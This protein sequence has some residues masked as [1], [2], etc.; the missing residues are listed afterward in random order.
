MP[1]RKKPAKE[2]RMKSTVIASSLV[3]AAALLLAACGSDDASDSAAG[4][5]TKQVAVKLT[6]AGCEP[7]QMKLDAGRVEFKVTNGGTGRVSEF[8]V[9]SGSRILGEKENLTPGLSG[10]FSITLQPGDYTL[11]CP[12]GSSAA[13]GTLTVTGGAGSPVA[14]PVSDAAAAAASAYHAYVQQQVAQLV[15]ATTAFVNAVKAGDSA[16]AQALYA[17]ARVPYERI[18]PVAE[19]FGDLD[20]QIDAREG[21][22]PA[23]QWGGFHRLEKALWQEN[24]LADMGPVADKLL[25]DT[26]QLQTL[27]ST[28]TF[29]PG[30]IA[31]GAVELLNEVSASKITGEEERYSHL[32]LL[33]FQANVDG[34]KAAFDAVRPLLT[35][36][37]PQ[38]AS[39]IATRFDA[40]NQ[41]LAPYKTGDSFVPYSQLTPDDTRALSQALDAL[42]EPLSQVAE[43][44]VGA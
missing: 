33:D 12:N 36:R 31:N 7:A 21:D 13:T 8:E 4:G 11:A 20:P 37:D 43:Q 14:S 39:D 23:E 35:Q 38:L 1:A 28:T 40:V 2:G 24:S 17:P 19:S 26:Q 32:D 22:V 3:I 6:D 44:V 16:Q 15:T 30:Q 10:S 29:E 5:S 34:A 27:V 9:L 18:E 41:A 42:A 25:A